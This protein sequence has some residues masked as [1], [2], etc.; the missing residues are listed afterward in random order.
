VSN[1]ENEIVLSLNEQM[2]AN[3]DFEVLCSVYVPEGWTRIET[4]HVACTE[5]EWAE[6]IRWVDSNFT[7]AYRENCGIWLIE[8]AEDTTMFMLRWV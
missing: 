2:R 3:I 7:G 1:L 8:K 5:Q 4:D 6:I